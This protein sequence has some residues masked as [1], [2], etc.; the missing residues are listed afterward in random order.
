LSKRI[1]QDSRAMHLLDNAQQ[2]ASRGI[3]LTQRMLAFARRQELK[4]SN[5]DIPTLVVGMTELLTRSLDSKVELELHFPLK[6]A[7]V[8][9][10]ANQLELAL[11]NLVVNARDAM[12]LGGTIVIAAKEAR[13]NEAP[14][15]GRYVCLSVTD[16][17][18]GMD[19]ETLA[20]AAEPFFTTKG[21]G[22]GTGLGLPMV[23][24]VAQQSGGRLVLT[25]EQ[26]R[27]TTA[28]IWLPCAPKI[29]ADSPVPSA[30]KARATAG[31]RVVMLV[32]DDVLVLH[33]AA[34]MLED[35]G[36]RVI[37]AA[38]GKQA[39]SLLAEHPEVE[40]LITDHAMPI[41]TG[42]EL[43][44]TL[45]RIYPSLPVVLATGYAELPADLAPD[46][47]R[48][49]KPFTQRELE[50]AISQAAIPEVVSH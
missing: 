10:D 26:G 33:S 41:M 27:G 23:H 2:G 25:S 18:E 16:S 44:E 8:L 49:A 11:L 42:A 9:A 31:P 28:E 24:G 39:L 5:V 12:P 40:V 3:A 13:L 6:L 20:R 1:Q 35:L 19:A 37:E 15:V 21:I 14:L 32:D 7:A 17:G 36:H 50:N 29:A 30:P 43:V 22:K 34:A 46:L 4:V 38:S 45:Q 47:T 48:L